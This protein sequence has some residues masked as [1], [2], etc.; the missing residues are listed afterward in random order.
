MNWNPIESAPKDGTLLA[1]FQNW[2]T[3]RLRYAH[4]KAIDGGDHLWRFV[5][6]DCEVSSD[7]NPVRWTPLPPAT[8]SPVTEDALLGVGFRK[9]GLKTDDVYQC[10]HLLIVRTSKGFSIKALN[11]SLIIESMEH[12]AEIAQALRIELGGGA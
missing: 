6:D 2:H 8:T 4:F 7:W 9:W 1:E 11:R 3:K 10:G 5:D 12:L